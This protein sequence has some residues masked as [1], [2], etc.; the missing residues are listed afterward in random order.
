MR[1][2]PLNR[3]R[4]DG[5]H[6]DTALYENS[7]YIGFVKPQVID[8][9]MAEY[10]NLAMKAAESES[11][12]KAVIYAI[13]EYEPEST[14]LVKAEMMTLCVPYQNYLEM[15]SKLIGSN[16]LFF[17]RGRKEIFDE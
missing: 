6:K 16:R 7:G 8:E 9:K 10:R 1:R 17:L 15:A 13:L 12:D 3:L 4:M 11:W 5:M 14:A 2:E